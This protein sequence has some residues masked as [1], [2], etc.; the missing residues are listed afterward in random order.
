[1]TL[2]A[3]TK[4]GHYE[5]L[6]LLGAGG[7]GEVYRARDEKLKRTVAIKVLPAS[8]TQD[9][10][11]MRRF[12]QEAQAAGG[13]N[14]PNIT[15]VYEL[16]E[17]DGSPYIVQ[18]LLEGETLRSRLAGG[19]LPVRKATDYAIQ[20]ARGLAAAHEKGIV[21]RDLKPENLFI[22]KDGRV[23]ILDFGLAKLTQADGAVGPQTN[24]PT[25]PPA[26]EPGVVMGTL[27]YMSPEQVK[28]K[29]ADARSDIFSFG[30]ILYEALSGSRAFH[31]DTAAETM[32][33]ILKEEP[34]DLSATNK[35]V[36]PG[37]ERVVRHC[38]EKNPEERFHSAHDLAFDLE[39]I[40]GAS[41][42][43]LETPHTRLRRPRLSLL[44]GLAF[45][46][47]GMAASYWAGMRAGHVQP[48]PFRQLTFRR[49]LIGSARFAPDGQTIL[50]SAS[51][52]GRPMEVFVS[53][54]DSPESRPFG[55][56][57]AEV[58]SISPSGEMAVS[59]SRR[60]SIPFTRTGTLARLG[61][62]GGG[63]PK[64]VLEDVQGAD[65]S[66]DGQSLAVVRQQGG[67]VRLEY[68]V[69]TLLYET[70]GWI[71][72]PRVS[73]RG[74]EVAFIDHPVQGDDAGTVTIVDRTGKRRA[75]SPL[76]VSAQGLSWSADG[77][78]VWFT[79]A[80]VG[81]NRALLAASRG[82]RVRL[83][84]Q[85]TGG[86]IIQDVSRKGQILVVQEKARQGISALAPGAPKERDLTWL[87]WSLIRDVTPDGQT[88]LFD[89]TG[90]GGG[91]GYSVYVRKAD[92][93]PAVRLGPG[94]GS[95]LSPDGR[96]ALA[97]TG[98]SIAH[99]LVLYPIGA[100]EPKT[101]PASGLRMGVLSWLPDGRRIVFSANEQDR[102]SR[103]WVQG[104]EDPKPRAFS[105]EG[106]RTFSKCV[107]PDGKAVV[108]IGP[109]QRFYLYPIEGG[110]PTPIAG[111]V[112]ADVPR[113]F[114]ADGRSIFV[115]NRGEVPQRVWKLDLASGKKE[116]WK[117]LVPPDPAGIWTISPVWITPDEK[118]YVYSYARSLADLYLVEGLK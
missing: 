113:G 115:R 103:L 104:I 69:G 17:H 79:A 85:A 15:S 33:A 77:S 6:A 10:E 91:S 1:M 37:L 93:S 22:T 41:T 66:P 54:L 80:T 48:T 47:A 95:T 89:E 62:T 44:A 72:H 58:L 74:D 19:A 14:H 57:P 43:T 96:L 23:K 18:E 29:S 55:L 102:G 111:L 92:G 34:P 3:G 110:E 107:S 88:F 67:K 45:A 108:A 2:S 21:H 61:M 112:P 24:L 97:V 52:D 28:G 8:L 71:G 30:A 64:E 53:R 65:W 49:G 116:L 31:R 114:T 13:L 9:A 42:P 36:Q 38:L 118:F 101:F 56:S 68:P 109:D 12:E 81:F 100:G 4:L 20:V 90:E 99:R 83:L 39:A 7:M 87:D 105:P 32:S 82:G 25:A 51:W 40:S 50:Y 27:G 16:G 84:A 117:E 59:L 94:V 98:E 78:E 60:G 70:A 26:T 46:L 63:A 73:A 75:I 106:Y 5:V 35:N 11:R 76:Y 86:L